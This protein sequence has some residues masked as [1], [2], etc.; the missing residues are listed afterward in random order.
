VGN[1]NSKIGREH[2]F[3][4]AKGKCF[5]HGT[6][7]EN[8]IKVIYF[9]TNNNM[10]TKSTYFPHKNIHKKTW[11]SPDGRTNYQMEGMHPAL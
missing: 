11:Q 8:G 1:F 10:I 5:L 2:V 6:P 4:P 9:A 3:K 7:N